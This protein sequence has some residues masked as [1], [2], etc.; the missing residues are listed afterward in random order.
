MKLTLA[1]NLLLATTAATTT[2]AANTNNF[3]D[4]TDKVWAFATSG[5]HVFTTDGKLET[6]HRHQDEVCQASPNSDDS[7]VNT[8]CRYVEGVDD[9]ERYVWVSNSRGDNE[10][11]P[12]SHRYYMDAYDRN[13][14][15]LVASIPTCSVVRTVK[16]APHRREIWNNCWINSKMEVPSDGQIDVFSTAAFGLEHQAVVLGEIAHEH[17]DVFIDEALP[18]MAFGFSTSG[19]TLFEIEPNTK[20]VVAEIDI[21]GSTAGGEFAFSKINKHLFIR[22]YNDC[23]C[24][25]DKDTGV[26]C[27]SSGELGYKGLKNVTVT[28]GPNADSEKQQDGFSG[29]F[30]RG[31]KA[32]TN[33]VWEYE[34]ATRRFLSKHVVP[35]ANG[36]KPFATPDGD[37]VLLAAGDGSNTVSVLKA[38]K[39]TG[40]PSQAV[41]TIQLSFGNTEGKHDASDIDFVQ[42]KNNGELYAIFSSVLHNHVMVAE[43]HDFY[44]AT[45]SR[46]VT[47]TNSVDITLH[48]GSDSSARWDPRGIN[49]RRI[50]V[51]PESPYF[52]VDAPERDEVM[53]VAIDFENIAKTK[54][55]NTIT[56]LDSKDLVY[57]AAGS[58][59]AGSAAVAYSSARA[60]TASNDKKAS[61]LS[62]VSIVLSMVAVIGALYVLIAGKRNNP[63]RVKDSS[64]QKYNK[65][66]DPEDPDIRFVK[67]DHAQ[68]IGAASLPSIK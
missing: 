15:Q 5:I 10:L 1:T 27:E 31:S 57:V 7:G 12:E 29:K 60:S 68:S 55:V 63:T 25:T 33:G 19:G 50:R 39:N 6:L 24:G 51:I 44:S 59:A 45:A 8:D 56:G 52:W 11:R 40:E 16:Y 14:A 47:V 2:S 21:P 43:L 61:V 62:I 32:D 38:S 34:P 48:E 49:T 4:T 22:N 64:A 30:C 66:F 65:E 58:T 35:G 17:G 41:G 9:G 67:E 3:V 46:P 36:A 18:L 13:T 23:S 37:F 20:D 54:I 42:D 53:V 26:A 28:T